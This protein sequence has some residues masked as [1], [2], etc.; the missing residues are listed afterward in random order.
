[1]N[2]ADMQALVAVI[3]TGSLAH[4]A[5]K[6]SLTQPAITR[7]IQRLE[8]ALGAT[9]LDRDVKPARPTA[10]G[11]AA[12]AECIRVL[13]AADS[14]KGAIGRECRPGRALRIGVSYG[15]ADLVLPLLMPEPEA[16]APLT[17]ET[18]RSVSLESA[19][20]ERRYD[21]V[22]LLRDA[23][24]EHATGEKVARLPVTVVAP[25]SFKLKRRL[26]L[27]DLRGHRWVLCPDGCGY[28]R[29]LEHGLYGAAQPLDVA[30]SIWG[31]FQQARLVAAGAGLGLLPLRILAE[32]AEADQL[33]IIDVSNFSAALDLWFVRS[34]NTGGLDRRFSALVAHLRLH[35]TDSLAK[36]S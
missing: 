15:A 22:L 28:R 13:N 26:S 30:A 7:R 6:L 3:E 35:F 29:A 23:M 9:L 33:H 8:E 24:R 12:Y 32:C 20:A 19:I 16:A 17:V 2:L 27:A 34:P 1:M 21:A 4:A 18:H 14:L 10:E 31:F 36:A 25:R 11:E 5:I